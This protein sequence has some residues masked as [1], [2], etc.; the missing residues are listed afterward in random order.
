MAEM[1]FHSL[2]LVKD[3]INAIQC[4]AWYWYINTMHIL[5]NYRLKWVWANL[6]YSGFYAALCLHWILI[7]HKAALTQLCKIAF[8]DTYNTEN[9]WEVIIYLKYISKYLLK[10]TQLKK[11]VCARKQNMRNVLFVWCLGRW[12]RW[13][14]IRDDQWKL[15][16]DSLIST[17]TLKCISSYWLS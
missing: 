16:S 2:M 15:D 14:G 12:K 3:S 9:I 5:L 10:P 13:Y 11:K 8:C 17:E 6:I 1:A 4:D 7:R